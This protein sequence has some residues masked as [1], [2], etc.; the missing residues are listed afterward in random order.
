MKNIQDLTDKLC[1]AFVAMEKDPKRSIEFKGRIQAAS[2]IVNGTRAKLVYHSLRKEVPNIKF[3][4]V[5]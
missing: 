5:K 3:M 2:V 1:E 4:N